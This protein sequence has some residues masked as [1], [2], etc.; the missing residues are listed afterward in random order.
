MVR[1]ASC[2]PTAVLTT[3]LV[4]VVFVLVVVMATVVLLVVRDAFM[5]R[6][7]IRWSG[8]LLKYSESKL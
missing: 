5:I 4:L 6:G 2:V 1:D 8:K 7:N 3:L